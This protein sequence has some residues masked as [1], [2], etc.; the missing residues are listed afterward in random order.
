M[1]QPDDFPQCPPGRCANAICTVCAAG[2]FAEPEIDA[3]A[4]FSDPQPVIA[5]PTA[6][7][8]DGSESI[9]IGAFVGIALGGVAL[10]VAVF[11]ASRWGRKRGNDGVQDGTPLV[12]EAVTVPPPVSPQTISNWTVEPSTLVAHALP[13]TDGDLQYNRQ[14]SEAANSRTNDAAVRAVPHY[15]DQVR[16]AGQAGTQDVR[17]SNLQYK[18]QVREAGH[19][20]TYNEHSPGRQDKD[21]VPLADQTKEAFRRG[22]DP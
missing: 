20:A 11:V 8:P 13:F 10:V 18:D 17:S 22:I 15:K 6:P 1:Y 16:E 14:E 12:A 5:A 3:S 21:Q 9:S 2:S 4:S 7:A 19:A